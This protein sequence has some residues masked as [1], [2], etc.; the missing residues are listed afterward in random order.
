M[1]AVLEFLLETKFGRV[2]LLCVVGAIVGVVMWFG[3]SQH[4]YDQGY[5]AAIESVAKRNK[6]ATDAV[7]RAK[8]RVERCAA[9]GGD[10][11]IA[12][13]MCHH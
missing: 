10:W 6:E 3:F 1:V 8:S 12:D 11:S 2:V 4:Y 9:T 5:R 13:G 7:Q